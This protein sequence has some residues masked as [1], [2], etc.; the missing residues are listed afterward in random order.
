MKI[1]D[2]AHVG[3]WCRMGESGHSVTP[4]NTQADRSKKG[5]LNFQARLCKQVKVTWAGTAR[6]QTFWGVLKNRSKGSH[7]NEC[8]PRIISLAGN[9]NLRVLSSLHLEAACLIPIISGQ[10]HIC[11][12]SEIPGL[13]VQCMHCTEIR[14]KWICM[15]IKFNAFC[16]L[17]DWSFLKDHTR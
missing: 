4:E 15:Q 17:R 6:Q 11:H 10:Y 5:L 1:D 9:Q 2:T 12:I 7:V 14:V 13:K 8:L 3:V 16:R